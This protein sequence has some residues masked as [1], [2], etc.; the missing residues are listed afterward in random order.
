MFRKEKHK[1]PFRQK[2]IRDCKQK[3]H[4]HGA[5]ACRRKIDF[6][7][8]FKEWLRI[9]LSSGHIHERGVKR[10]EYVMGRN[11]DKGPYTIDN[12]R[13]I[14][15]SENSKEVWKNSGVKIRAQIVSRVVSRETKAKMS[16]AHLDRWAI[17][18]RKWH[19]ELYGTF[20]K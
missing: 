11:G 4:E 2:F 16:K 17:K 18:T 3:Y 15:C 12:V 14:T 6:D 19:N 5:G 9:W 7:L 1:Y 10:G 8:T 20:K 13:I